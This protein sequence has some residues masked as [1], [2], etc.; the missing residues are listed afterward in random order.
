MAMDYKPYPYQT[1]CQSRIVDQPAIGLFLDMGLG[2]TVITL[3]ALHELKYHRFA[4][5]KVLIV[6]PKK[7]AEDTWTRE[8]EKWNH[9]A[10]L[11]VVPVLGSVAQRNRALSTPA[12][13]YVTNRENVVWLVQKYGRAWPF[14]TV[15][16]DESSSFKNHQSKRFKALKA[17]RP[18]ISRIIELTGTPNPNGLTD[19]WA[20]IYLLDGGQRLGKTISVYRD[21]FFMPDK[22][23]ASVIFSYKP[24]DGAEEEI[25]SRLSDLCISMKSE[26][27][28]TLPDRI[29]EDIP[30]VLDSKSQKAY[31]EFQRNA[32][33]QIEQEN[34]AENCKS[35][36]AP[37]VI[38]YH[39]EEDEERICAVLDNLGIPTYHYGEN[40][41]TEAWKASERGALLVLGGNPAN[42]SHPCISYDLAITAGSAGVLNGKLLQLC[43]GAIYAEDGQVQ[44]VHDCKIDAFMEC[45]ERLN[46]QHALVLYKFEHD[47]DRLMAALSKTEL[48]AR[49]Y[50]T[51]QDKTDWNNGLVDILMTHPASCG[52]GLNLQEGGHHVIWFGLTWA[53]EEYQQA[54]KRLHRQG[55]QHPVII[56]HL[57]TQGGVDEDVMKSLGCKA[58]TQE[59]LLQALKVRVQKAKEAIKR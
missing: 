37:T 30:V 58:D 50:K 18:L 54:N 59:H 42:I 21:T 2:K 28:L 55:Q 16:L 29:Y 1:Y 33:L 25:Y 5:R 45:V 13:I 14:D 20:Q 11:R 49:V 32:V 10:G 48:R 22:R 39:F 38:C 17:V 34:F 43:N 47:R 41:D 15:V 4:I 27:Y 31:D 9:L 40:T 6:A 57:V 51:A 8:A 3:S 56:H 36:N 46:G 26:D 53:L 12:D 7:V 44:E 52:Y 35:I 24:K 23:S 19:L